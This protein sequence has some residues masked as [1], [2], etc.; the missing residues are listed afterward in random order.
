MTSTAAMKDKSSQE[1]SRRGPR[2]GHEYEDR[3]P[4]H[5]SNTAGS[6]DDRNRNS[7]RHRSITARPRERE[8]DRDSKP[9]SQGRSSHASHVMSSE[10]AQKA[11]RLLFV[12]V[13]AATSFFT[14]FK[15]QYQKEVRAIEA[16]AGQTILEKLWERK[17]RHIDGKG[18][19]VR[20][21]LKTTA[22]CILR[23]MTFRIGFGIVS[24]MHMRVLELIRP[25]RT[26]DWLGN[27][28]VPYKS[29][30]NC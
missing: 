28:T 14:N 21:A 2:S 10:E 13:K 23:S 22:Y 4:R 8:R 20:T 16:Y 15:E 6:Q 30:A 7:S 29:L 27:W 24:V 12:Q 17:I 19:Q 9:Y 11:I 26:A 5:K 25:V 18:V 1:T 3:V